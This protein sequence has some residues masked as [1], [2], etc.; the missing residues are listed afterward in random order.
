MVLPTATNLFS[1]PDAQLKEQQKIQAESED[2]KHF[3]TAKNLSDEQDNSDIKGIL[4]ESHMRTGQHYNWV[5]SF[6]ACDVVSPRN[7]TVRPTLSGEHLHRASP[8]AAAKE[9]SNDP[10]IK[11]KIKQV[12]RIAKRA[13]KVENRRERL[14]AA[15]ESFVDQER[16]AHIANQG[17]IDVC[18]RAQRGWHDHS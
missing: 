1:P 9:K 4:R 3:G 11:P 14:Q 13:R 15:N 2:M 17:I 12:W 16:E 10:P 5:S 18:A 7:I 8:F 6:A